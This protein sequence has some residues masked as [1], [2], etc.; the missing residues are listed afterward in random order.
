GMMDLAR[1]LSLMKSTATNMVRPITAALVA[2]YTWRF[3]MP[4]TEDAPDA[5]LTIAPF[6]RLSIAGR[7]ALMVRCIDLT[8]RSN[9]K[10]QSDSEQSSTQPWW[11]KPAQF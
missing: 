11:T 3:G 9:E 7:N 6:L 5:M 8:L 4:R 1:I 2:P 10:S